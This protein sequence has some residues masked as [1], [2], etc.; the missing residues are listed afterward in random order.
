M[1]REAIKC[2]LLSIFEETRVAA[3]ERFWFDSPEHGTMLIDARLDNEKREVYET[4]NGGE[5][6]ILSQAPPESVRSGKAA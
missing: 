4:L 2:V 5:K 3:I 6:W 1:E